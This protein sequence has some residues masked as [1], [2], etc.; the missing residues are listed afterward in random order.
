MA[1]GSLIDYE[2]Q[3]IKKTV[4]STT[5]AELYSLMKCFG[6]CQFLRGLWMDISGEV[7]NL[8]IRTD[9]KNLVTTARTIH[10]PDRNETIHMISVAKGSL[11]QEVFMILAHIPTQ[12]CLADCL[13][14]TSA[15]AGNLITAVQTGKLLDVDIQPVVQTLMVHKAFLSTWC[16]KFMHTREKEVFFLNTLKIS[17]AP[18]PQEG[19]FQVMFVGSQQQKEQKELNTSERKG[20][21]ATKTTSALADSCFQFPWSVVPMTALT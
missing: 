18:T 5:V 14:K 13:T 11:P 2:S 1:F 15:K 21:D 16:R 20:Q 10:L 12:N 17:L 4:L 9:A 6:S 7:A 19:P 8:H 3:K